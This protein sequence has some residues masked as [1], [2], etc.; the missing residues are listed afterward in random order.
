MTRCGQ[1]QCASARDGILS[2]SSDPPALFEQISTLFKFSRC[3]QNT[4]RERR[5]GVDTYLASREAND[6]MIEDK[7]KPRKIQV[8]WEEL[9]LHAKRKAP[10]SLKWVI[11]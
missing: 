9:S 7:N 3:R 8:L 1:R 2:R 11:R 5:G 10:W 6:V 4:R